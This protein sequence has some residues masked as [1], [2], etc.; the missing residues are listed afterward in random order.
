LP[1]PVTK[2][3][4]AFEQLVEDATFT[5]LLVFSALV[6]LALIL[7][8]VFGETGWTAPIATLLRSLRIYVFPWMIALAVLSIAREAW[9]VRIYSQYAKLSEALKTRR[10]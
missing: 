5:L 4:E 8:L 1:A 7:V 6:S 3:T 2:T 10:K 9:L